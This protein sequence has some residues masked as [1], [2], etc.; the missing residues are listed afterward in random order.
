MML[1]SI[2]YIPL[3][4]K[5]MPWWWG[6]FLSG[7]GDSLVGSPIYKK[8]RPSQHKANLDDLII[9]IGISQN[10]PSTNNGQ[11]ST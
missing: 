9:V 11:P 6:K 10:S 1:L 4:G 7:G 8:N 5:T 2:A 3:V